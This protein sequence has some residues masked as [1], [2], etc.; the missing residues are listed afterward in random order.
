MGVEA[1]VQR[2][3][4]VKKSILSLPDR[5]KVEFIKIHHYPQPCAEIEF[6]SYH[7]NKG[8]CHFDLYSA[9]QLFHSPRFGPLALIIRAVF[10]G[11]VT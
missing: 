6:K 11:I 8:L 2:G 5:H 1:V 10:Y 3:S 9:W 4:L 7:P